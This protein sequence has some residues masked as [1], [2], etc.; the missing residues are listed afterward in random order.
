MKRVPTSLA[1]AAAL[2]FAAF[3]A[4]AAAAGQRQ[5]PAGQPF[6]LAW[7]GDVTL[8][9]SYGNP[10]DA[11]RGLLA[12]VTAPL[13]AADVGA[14]NLE[15]TLGS[16]GSSKCGGGGSGGGGNCFAFQAP[17]ANVAGLRVAGV[18]VVNLANNHAFDFGASGQAQTIGAL[19]DAGVAYSGRPGEIR[20]LR[21]PHTRVAF[22]GFSAY[23]WSA[24]IGD[25][26]AVR[27]LVG[28]AARQANVVVAFV[29]AGAEGSGQI[30]TPNHDEIAFGENRGNPR[31]F[32][33]AA[34]D[35]GADLVVGS[36]PHVLR[37]I[38]LDRG[39]LIA[40]SLGNLAG[41]RNFGI[42]PVTGTSGLLSVHLGPDGTFMSGGLRSLRLS[43]AGIPAADLGGAAAHLV[44]SVSRADFG[45]HGVTVAGGRLIPHAG[46]R[47][48]PPFAHIR[49][50]RIG[51]R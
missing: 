41:Y 10:P 43:G 50:R 23:P 14:V 18:D 40:Y 1:L 17:A 20:V 37:G 36:G 5:R 13:R 35:A 30:H 45:A 32:A 42:G 34:I 16:G 3:P 33:H 11:A 46:F 28:A 49:P 12:A 27:A 22:V 39:R 47:R 19:A 6:T 25:L 21:L 48:A 31:A 38:E 51:E 7:G 29:H 24:P 8:G 9:S 44:S 26:G 2:A 4:A 15:G